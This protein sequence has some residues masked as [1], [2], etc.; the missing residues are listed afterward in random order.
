MKTHK[1]ALARSDR[2]FSGVRSRLIVYLGVKSVDW[3]INT[4]T[5]KPL[6]NGGSHCYV[7]L[8]PSVGCQMG[9]YKMDMIQ[10]RNVTSSYLQLLISKMTGLNSSNTS[11]I[12]SRPYNP[13]TFSQKFNVMKNSFINMM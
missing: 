4:G 1:R 13:F 3:L 7:L 6:K 11:S 8:R 5:N 9:N 10:L 2:R 12:F